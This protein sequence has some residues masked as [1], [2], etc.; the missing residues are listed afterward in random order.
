MNLIKGAFPFFVV[1]LIISTLLV[2]LCK[3]IGFKLN[4]YAIENE[5]TVHSGKIV[6]IGGMA[7][8]L[9]FIIGMAIFMKADST[10]NTIL[11]GGFV[12]F[13]GGLIDDIYDIKPLQKLLFIIAG[14]II[15][16]TYGNTLLMN[17]YLPFNI[18]ISNPIITY[19]I[20]FLWIVGITNAINLIDGLD[21]LS[22]GIS[23]IVTITIG[24]LGF[25]MGRRDISVIALVLSGSI[26]G[27]L[28]YNFHPASIF[29][30]DCGALFLGFTIACLSLLGFKTTAIITLGF[31]ILILFIPIS[32][33]LIA[34]LRRKLSNKKISEAD[35]GHLHHVL[36]Y[37][38]NLGHRNTVIVL[39]IV[40]A[41]FGC[42]AILSY[43][44]ETY[45]LIMIVILL[46][47]AE[48]FVEITG[49]INDK[50]HP[51]IGLC[52]RLTGWPKKKGKT[53]EKKQ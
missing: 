17:I 31:P 3:Q 37:K 1:P 29:M 23:F 34:I 51:M 22:S 6:R 14:A 27:F 48:L 39:Y 28:P 25:F 11:L 8:Y 49:M 46:F 15:V 4:I 19:G 44:N 45:G 2:P 40:A 53:D 7:I 16:L 21:G 18:T 38:L 36:M 30:G 41:L 10:I 35:R 33:T 5:R 9:A 50:F 52:R 47:L 42:A 24:L 20:S 26:L 32:D 43:F 12:V 13:I